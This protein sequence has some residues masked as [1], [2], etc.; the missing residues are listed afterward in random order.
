MQCIGNGNEG[1]DREEKYLRKDKSS[2]E[3]QGRN[4][5]LR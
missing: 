5:G 3:G 4:E 2:S 1:S